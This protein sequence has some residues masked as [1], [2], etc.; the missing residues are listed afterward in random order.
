MNWIALNVINSITQLSAHTKRWLLNCV[1][2]EWQG[3][4]REKLHSQSAAVG[5]QRDSNPFWPDVFICTL[6]GPLMLPE[7]LCS[8]HMPRK[9]EQDNS[10]IKQGRRRLCQTALRPGRSWMPLSWIWT[11]GSNHLSVLPPQH[12]SKWMSTDSL[13]RRVGEDYEK[14]FVGRA[15]LQSSH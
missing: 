7:P 5:S 2:S 14:L 10:H 12:S 9:Q 8:L 3:C 6:T 15:L 4:C 1:V 13:K 11:P